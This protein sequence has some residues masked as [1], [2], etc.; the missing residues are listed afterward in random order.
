M[1]RA[2]QRRAVQAG[3]RELPPGMAGAEWRELMAALGREPQA[4]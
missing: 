2:E 1:P 4:D 3:V